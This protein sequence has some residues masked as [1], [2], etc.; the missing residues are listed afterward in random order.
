[1]SY[2]YIISYGTSASGP[3][4][5]AGTSS[6]A[7]FTINGLSAGLNYWIQVIA[8]D[9]V[10]GL[11][12]SPTVAGP[13]Q[14]GT[15][16]QESPNL[17]TITSQSQTLF[18]SQTPGQ[19]APTGGPF[20]TWSITGQGGQVV[21]NGAAD[22]TTSS[23][24]EI[25]YQNHT[26]YHE[27][28][29]G[30]SFGSPGWWQW[31]GTTNYPSATPGSGSFTDTKGNVWS[32]NG[33]GNP[34][35]NGQTDTVSHAQIIYLIGG[36]VW[37]L[38]Q[39]NNWYSETPTGTI[40]SAS[41][42]AWAGPTT[43]SPITGWAACASPSGV[44]LTITGISLSNNTVSNTAPSGTTVGAVTVSLSSGTF[45]G[46]LSLSGANAS[47]FSVSGSNLITNAGSL[48]AGNYSIG[49]TATQSTAS[50]SPFGPSSFTIIS[51]AST[52]GP[53]PAASSGF[54]T[55]DFSLPQNYPNGGS[56][57][58]VVSQRLWGASGGSAAD[59]GFVMMTN[60]AVTA[61][62]GTINW[63]LHMFVDVPWWN[64]DLSVNTSLAANL[65]AN[66]P[67]WDPLG[68]SG[69]IMGG[70]F[71]APNITSASAYGTAMGN[72]YRYLS[73]A[74]MSNG[75]PLPLVGMVGHNE[76]DNFGE[77]TAASYYNAAITAIKNVNANAAVF[78]P[79]AS[80]LQWFDFD[81]Q[82]SNRLTGF[83]WDA[84]PTG[85]NPSTT[86]TTLVGTSEFAQNFHDASVNT[87]NAGLQA[88]MVG[89]YSISSDGNVASSAD[90]SYPMALAAAKWAIDAL[91]NSRRPVYMC[92]WTHCADT[93]NN[94][95]GTLDV[96]NGSGQ[97]CPVG[98]FY[99]Q[100]VRKV[101]G[102]RWQVPTTPAGFY[103]LAVSPSPGHC[104]MLLVN[105][106]GGT[107]NA[108]TV[109]FSHWPVNTSGNATATSWQL[110]TQS[111]G[112]TNTDP[113]TVNPNLAVNSGVTAA[114]NFPDPSI[115][116]ISI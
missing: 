26:V 93:V 54:V 107:R 17:T 3:W 98:W 78:G 104:T 18:S 58:T 53:G 96:I 95:A 55:A 38:D 14:T 33:S 6:V 85:S 81:T 41:Q 10:T 80:F 112:Y 9:T 15:A 114:M 19:A 100:A 50:N 113:A 68:I 94:F 106:G 91:N 69:I 32:L 48:T 51:Q 24:L 64:A 2:S 108:Q 46:S 57:Q 63:G 42:L 101:F 74:K 109:A 40:T 73:T 23:L 5:Q 76:P 59:S 31:T 49:L 16:T 75:N 34:V 66:F 111:Q 105:Y 61:A 20:D 83:M 87:T 44:P 84:F 27:E 25:F 28:S 88:Y 116:I 47:S 77:A 92:K 52:G 65:L 39:T 36:A 82:V 102:P 62:A 67:K 8:V 90:S 56:G 37:Q 35:V 29:N 30:N 11:Q 99:A 60:S 86:D 21:H 7:S 4:T 22:S 71:N 43:T 97:I 13:F 115:T 45:S 1:M 72:L 12:S 110:G 103:A 70:D 79:M 89:G